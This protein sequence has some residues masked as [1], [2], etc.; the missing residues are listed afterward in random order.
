MLH[1]HV[2]PADE[3]H[4]LPTCFGPQRGGGGDLAHVSA[5]SGHVGSMFAYRFLWVTRGVFPLLKNVRQLDEAH[6]PMEYVS[7][8]WD[9]S[10]LFLEEGNLLSLADNISDA[11]VAQAEAEAASERSCA[12]KV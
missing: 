1:P 2:P 8:S 12:V 6:R 11:L 9:L 5:S 10:G 7:A 4:R 3:P